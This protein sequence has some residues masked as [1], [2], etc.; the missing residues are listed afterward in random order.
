MKV[1]C[2]VFKFNPDLAAEGKFASYTLEM[3]PSDTVLDALIQIYQDYDPA[4]AFRYACGVVRCGECA[5][6]VNGSPCLAC[7]KSVESVMKIEPLPNLPLIKDLVIDRRG[8]FEHIFKLLPQLSG[9]EATRARL[10]SLAPETAKE[11][12]EQSVRFSKCFE[13]LICQSQCPIYANESE[14]FVGPLGLLW[15]AQMGV[16]P[17]NEP[18]SPKEVEQALAPCLHCG[19]CSEKCPAEEDL[20]SLALTTLDNR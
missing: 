16:N 2:D 19:A 7:E 6:L 1:K 5:M 9:I 17:A 12:I 3:E 13:C 4:L 11:S 15:L 20:V 18:I 14:A 8:V 10:R